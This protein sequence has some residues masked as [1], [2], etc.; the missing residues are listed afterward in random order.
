MDL[1]VE[2]NKENY[3]EFISYLKSLGEEKYKEFNA[4]LVFTKYKMLGIRLPKLRNIA[5]EIFK[6]DYKGFLK[7]AGH[8]YYEEVMIYL[9]VLSMIKDL[10]IL[11]CYFDKAINLIDNWAL[12]DTFCNSL[13]IVSKNKEYFLNKIALLNKSGEEFKVRVGLILLLSHYVEEK[14]LDIIIA[15][16]DLIKSNAYYINMAEAWLVCEIF[17]KYPS[18]GLKYLENNSLSPFTLNK[19]I[20][21]IRDSYRVS[22]EMKNYILQYK[23]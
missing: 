1:K 8:K 3:L 21:K 5:K 20:S 17:I 2:W 16:L 10:S 9:L 23:K 12:C 13:K 22:K 15:Y 14:Y 7:Q 11:E 19:A 4:K 6:G 18:R